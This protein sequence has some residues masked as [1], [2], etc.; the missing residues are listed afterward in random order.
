MFLECPVC[1]A[2]FRNI[3]IKMNIFTR[4]Q[5][6]FVQNVVCVDEIWYA[7]HTEQIWRCVIA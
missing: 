4:K 5:V 2:R 1:Q 3:F 7:F 6:S